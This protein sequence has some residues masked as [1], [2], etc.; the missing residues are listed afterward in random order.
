MYTRT[1]RI[2]YTHTDLARNISIRHWPYLVIIINK[3]RLQFTPWCNVVFIRLHTIMDHFHRRLTHTRTTFVK[4]RTPMGSSVTECARTLFRKF[5]LRRT[6]AGTAFRNIFSPWHGTTN[7]TPL[8]QNFGSIFTF[9]NHFQN[10]NS[11]SHTQKCIEVNKRNNM[12]MDKVTIATS[13]LLIE[14]QCLTDRSYSPTFSW[15]STNKGN[16]GTQMCV[17]FIRSVSDTIFAMPFFPK[18]PA[19]H[20]AKHCGPQF[21]KHWCNACRCWLIMRAHHNYIL[22]QTNVNK[23]I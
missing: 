21:E 17:F 10:R 4:F 1:I 18:L 20:L 9:R 19:D 8:R 14:G 23:L 12:P 3:L 7:T 13:F 22:L 16:F 5:F 2:P 15:R 6:E 11:A